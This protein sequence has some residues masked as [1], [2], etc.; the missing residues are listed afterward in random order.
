MPLAMHY[1]NLAD[2][3]LV[4]RTQAGDPFV[5]DALYQRKY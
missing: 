4:E 3:E 2:G 1:D 5:Y